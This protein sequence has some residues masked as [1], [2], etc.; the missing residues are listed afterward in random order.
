MPSPASVPAQG[1]KP[2]MVTNRCRALVLCALL[3]AVLVF[4]GARQQTQEGFQAARERGTKAYQQGDF[5]TAIEAF[6]AA[7]SEA[8]KL[9]PKVARTQYSLGEVLAL[10]GKRLEAIEK[11]KIAAELNPQWPVPAKR[12]GEIW[13]RLGAPGRAIESLERAAE[14]APDAS[15]VLVS[16]GKAYAVAGKHEDAARVLAKALE[17]MP[18]TALVRAGALLERAKKE[19]VA[20]PGVCVVG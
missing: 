3:P 19:G 14:L 20:V 8:A 15:P 6:E 7:L 5:T 18:E 2:V 1:V 4:L 16:L 11:M 17:L 13:L 10:R 9:R 12:I